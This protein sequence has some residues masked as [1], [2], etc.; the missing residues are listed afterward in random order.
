MKKIAL[1]ITV[2]MFCFLAL[3]GCNKTDINKQTKDISSAIAKSSVANS[4]A[5]S[6][7]ISMT[8][9]KLPSPPTCKRIKDQQTIHK[10]IEYI[11]SYKKVSIEN[12]NEKGWQILITATLPGGEIK[13]YSVIGEKLQ[14]DK[15]CYKISKDFIDN[16]EK[17]YDQIDVPEE[18][19]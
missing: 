18:K 3:L 10:V 12:K 6:E 16:L 7:N 14:I 17:L 1:A 13:Q 9:A 5:K 2:I 4:S 19:Y 8:F 11:D 15:D